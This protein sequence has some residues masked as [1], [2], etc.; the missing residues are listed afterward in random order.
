MEQRTNEWFSE[1]AGKV[2]AS[3]VADVMA[4]TKTGDSANRANYMAQLITERRQDFPLTASKTR[5]CNGALKP[6]HRRGRCIA[7]ETGLDVEE[8]GFASSQDCDD[9]RKP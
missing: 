8:V 4:K 9:R 1:R 7:P 3:K 5:R 2:T 6:N